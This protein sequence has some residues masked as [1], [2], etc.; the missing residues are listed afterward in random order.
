M[1]VLSSLSTHDYTDR[2]TV[3]SD[4]HGTPEQFARAIFG[5][6]P[7][8]GELFIWRLLLRLRLSPGRSPG[9]IAGW[10]IGGRGPDWI[11]MEAASDA[12]SANLVVRAGGGTVSLSTFIRY[13]RTPA[14]L[15]WPPLSAVHRVLAPRALRGGVARVE[16]AAASATASR[17]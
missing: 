1:T 9:T 16:R 8:A 12:L 3:R 5:D 15:L 7:N 13:D 14:R 10:R 17:R 6:V 11:R 2:F 4:A